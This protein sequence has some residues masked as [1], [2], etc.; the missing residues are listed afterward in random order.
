MSSKVPLYLG[1]YD[2]DALRLHSFL[3]FSALW[4]LLL[5][6]PPGSTEIVTSYRLNFS[7]GLIGTLVSIAFLYGYVPEQFATM[8]TISYFTVDLL[9]II[10]NDFVFKA[11]SYQTPANRRMEYF[12]HLF[13]LFVGVTSEFTYQWVCTFEHNPFI[14]LV[15]YS[16]ASTPIL[17]V[18]RYT[19]NDYVGLLFFLTFIVC[20]LYFLGLFFMPDCIRHCHPIAGWGFSLPYYTINIYFAYGMV[21]KIVKKVFSSRRKKPSEKKDS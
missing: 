16:E 13:C 9:N 2:P 15:A 18:W 14:E 8:S 11:K 7:A 3:G 4:V 5:V 1:D 6:L 21:R 17:M 19:G 12:H 10:L 20:R